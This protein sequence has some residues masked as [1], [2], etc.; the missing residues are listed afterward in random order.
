MSLVKNPIL[1]PLQRL[2]G[3][4]PAPRGSI[5]LDDENISQTLPVVPH[6]MRRSLAGIESGWF[7]GLMENV[8]GAADFESSFIDP[9]N[10]GA[11]AVAPYPGTVESDFDVWVLGVS[12]IR[13]S[14]AGGLTGALFVINPA[15]TSQGWGVDDAAA[16]VLG[17]PALK[18]ARFDGLETTITQTFDP[19]ITEAGLT[20]QP[21][22]IRVP[23]GGLLGFDTESAAAAEFQGQWLIGL[24]P[25]GLGQDVVT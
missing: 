14:G 4:S 9:Y 6:L 18:V 1:A 17:T 24:F 2:I 19:M 7:L 20:Y 3:T 16:Q 13:S 12:G 11:L 10:P 8:H 22:G 21:V 15:D 23:R 25:A 5:N